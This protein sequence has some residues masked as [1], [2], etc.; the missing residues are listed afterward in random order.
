MEDEPTACDDGM[1]KPDRC[2]RIVAT[3]AITTASAKR[4]R[5]VEER[6]A[7]KGRAGTAS[8]P[9]SEKAWGA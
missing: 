4:R 5:I 9:F 7:K 2:R 3:T 8:D 1:E 6:V